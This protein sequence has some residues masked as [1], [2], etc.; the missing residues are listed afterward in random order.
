MRTVAGIPPKYLKLLKEIL[1]R[2]PEVNQVLLYGSRAKGCATERS[3]V[4]L[5]ITQSQVSRDV[6][7]NILSD[8]EES[9][10]PYLVDLQSVESIQNPDLL[11]HIER[12]GKVVYER[13][14]PCASS[15]S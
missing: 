9:D 11:E 3:D 10:I 8:L 5:V 13:A 7:G 6:V 1:S 2:Y 15:K 12:V 4:D 14:E